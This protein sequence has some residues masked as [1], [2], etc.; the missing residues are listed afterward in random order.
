MA[1]R[2]KRPARKPHKPRAAKPRDFKAEYGR[3]IAR[4]LEKG[5]TRQAA[6]GHKPQEHIAR[7][8]RE[9]AEN[10]VTG[11]QLKTIRAFL[12]RFNSPDYKDMPTEADLVEFVQERDWEAFKLYVK[13][14][15]AVRRKYLKAEKSG[16]LVAVHGKR[17][18]G[19]QKLYYSLGE[20][21]LDYYVSKSEVEPQ[22][23]E[24]WLYY[25]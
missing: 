21:S 23:V 4:A 18:N 19:S 2:K 5:K 15:D 12:K 13:T 11:S 17:R 25:H 9:K 24:Q 14:W 16:T 1:T 7:R 6:R 22:G 20:H 3:R 8:E 10:G